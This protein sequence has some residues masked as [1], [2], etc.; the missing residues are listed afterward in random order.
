MIFG[1]PDKQ[2][3]IKEKWDLTSVKELRSLWP[4]KH[5]SGLFISMLYLFQDVIVTGVD[6]SDPFPISDV[7]FLIKSQKCFS[8]ACAL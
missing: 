4:V 7:V 6:I 8:N 5:L 3:K 1:C 2:I